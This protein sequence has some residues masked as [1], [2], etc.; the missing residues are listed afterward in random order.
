MLILSSIS[1]GLKLW[2]VSQISI[3]ESSE[4]FEDIKFLG[5]RSKNW[6][7]DSLG[8]KVYQNLESYW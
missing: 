7:K 3:Y 2:S 5:G 1:G 8:T 6:P 4:I